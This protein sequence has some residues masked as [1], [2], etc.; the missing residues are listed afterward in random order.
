[1]FGKTNKL[2]PIKMELISFRY[3]QNIDQVLVYT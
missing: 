3:M 2:H 1:M